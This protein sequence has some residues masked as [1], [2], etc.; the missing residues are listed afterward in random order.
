MKM[1]KII[2]LT[3]ILIASVVNAQNLVENGGFERSYTHLGQVKFDG[4]NFNRYLTVQKVIGYRGNAAKV[5]TNNATFRVSKH[6]NYN[7]IK[8]EPNKEYTLSF[9]FKGEQASEEIEPIIT[10]Y[11]K[12]GNSLRARKNLGKVVAPK[13]WTKKTFTFTA[14]AIAV[15]VN[16]SFRVSGLGRSITIDEVSI[17]K[18]GEG[19]D[20]PV[21]SGIQITP[22]QREIEI[23]W[24]RG[25]PNTKWEVVVNEESKIVNTNQYIAT[26]LTPN[27]DYRIKIRT[28]IGTDKS[29]FSEEKYISTRNFNKSKNDLERVP[30]LRTLTLDG[31]PPQTIDLFFNDLYNVNAKIDYFI[32]G[33]VIQP[34]NNKLHFDKKGSQ[35]LK[36]I[37]KEEKGLEWE[38]EYKLNVK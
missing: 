6:G 32:D 8:I 26:G 3:G 30:H 10:W 36:M 9:W 14:P 33:K 19:V 34:Q 28:I 1:K 25:E 21:P 2:L 20:V 5:Y 17:E 27:S 12:N 13:E 31:M 7:I 4:W 24:Y 18:T 16:L 22:F 35:I 29:E 15:T 38:I 11:D 37:I 23:S